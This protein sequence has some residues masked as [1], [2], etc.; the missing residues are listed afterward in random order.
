MQRMKNCYF[1]YQ[2]LLLFKTFLYDSRTTE[3]VILNTFIHKVINTK[4]I[5]KTIGA[6]NKNKLQRYNVKWSRVE[7]VLK[8]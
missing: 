3:S 1:S 7:S 8:C 5:D 4:E 6:T 2:I